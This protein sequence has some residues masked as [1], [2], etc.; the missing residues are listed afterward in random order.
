MIDNSTV[1]EMCGD[2]IRVSHGF[3]NCQLL[4]CLA[5]SQKDGTLSLCLLHLTFLQAQNLSDTLQNHK[6]TLS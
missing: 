1:I 2:Y 6:L 4:A 5:E 3:Q